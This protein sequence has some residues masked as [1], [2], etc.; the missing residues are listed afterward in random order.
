MKM[1]HVQVLM[2]ELNRCTEKREKKLKMKVSRHKWRNGYQKRCLIHYTNL[3]AIDF[4]KIIQL[5]SIS[6]NYGR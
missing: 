5:Y 3:F 2:V 1:H 4:I 6:M